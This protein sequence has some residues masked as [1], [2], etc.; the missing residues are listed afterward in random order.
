MRQVLTLQFGILIREFKPSNILLDARMTAK[1]ADMGL[2]LQM[3][4]RTY[5]DTLTNGVKGTFHYIAPEYMN[6]G[7]QY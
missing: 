3:D 2:A 6:T 7:M 1:V 5:V 4:A